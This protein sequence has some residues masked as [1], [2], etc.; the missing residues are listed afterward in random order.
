MIT[1]SLDTEKIPTRPSPTPQIPRE[2][3]AVKSQIQDDLWS[4][5][6]ISQSFH[7]GPIQKRKGYA[8]IAFSWLAATVDSLFLAGMS[9]LFLVAFAFVTKNSLHMPSSQG[10]LLM[11]GSLVLLFLSCFY[12]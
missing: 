5:S 12:M 9:L 11:S 4:E 7:R 8:L 1:P 2:T 6:V 10:L 3:P